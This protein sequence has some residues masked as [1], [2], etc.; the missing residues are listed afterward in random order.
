MSCLLA[1]IQGL[2]LAHA[3][4]SRQ[5]FTGSASILVVWGAFRGT[6]A[7]CLAPCARARG[8][9]GVIACVLSCL[10]CHGLLVVDVNQCVVHITM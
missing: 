8:M 4:F 1:L 6:L 9:Q 7:S 5:P 3:M 2:D 10:D